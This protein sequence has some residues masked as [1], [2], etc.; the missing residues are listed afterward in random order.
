LDHGVCCDCSAHH[1]H[2]VASQRDGKYGL[3]SDDLSERRDHALY[4][5]LGSGIGQFAP[6]GTLARLLHVQR[7]HHFW[8][9]DHRK[10]LQRRGQGDRRH[11]H[12]CVEHVLDHDICCGCSTHHRHN[13][14]SQR[15]GGYRLHGDG[16]GEWR[17][18]ALHSELDGGIGQFAPAGTVAR[19]LHL[20]RMHYFWH[21]DH[22]WNLQRRGQGDRRHEHDCVEHVLDH[23]STRGFRARDYYHLSSQRDRRY[24]V[25]DDAGGDRRNSSL[26]LE[27][28]GCDGLAPSRADA[29]LQHWYHLWNY[30]YWRKLQ[31]NGDRDGHQWPDRLQDLPV[32]GVDE[33]ADDPY[34][35]QRHD[36]CWRAF[37]HRAQCVRRYGTLHL[38][39]RSAHRCCA[40]ALCVHRWQR[41]QW[42]DA[43]FPARQL[44]HRQLH[45][46]CNCHGL[47]RASHRHEQYIHDHGP[48]GRG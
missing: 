24:V 35:Q 3:H 20:Q 9:A 19:F 15:D 45:L 39:C 6:A 16:R 14:S 21:S 17:H 18:H 10:Y 40:V 32:H 41:R 11:E 12:D 26:Q 33:S 13:L 8:H 22:R 46:R 31:R 25:H 28:G 1:R 36:S 34:Q 47:L 38:V 43:R 27:M 30:A 5:E 23:D 4:L 7:V 37:R 2:H 42:L 48:A 29:G 44:R